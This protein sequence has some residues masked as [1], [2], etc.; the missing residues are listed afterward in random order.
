MNELFDHTNVSEGELQILA[1]SNK[2][3]KF[4]EIGAKF[5]LAS[6]TVLHYLESARRKLYL[7]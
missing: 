4:K 6:R 2:R 5:E 3:K 7:R 1:L